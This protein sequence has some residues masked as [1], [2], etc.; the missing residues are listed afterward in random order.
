M[1]ITTHSPSLPVIENFGEI[2]ENEKGVL[3]YLIILL[4]VLCSIIS[5]LLTAAFLI[6]SLLLWGHFKPIKFFWFLTQ[7]TLSVFLISALNLLVNVPATLLL[8]SQEAAQSVTFMLISYTI[9]FFHYT[10]LFSNL[11]ISI[12]R[13]FVFFLRY[14]TDKVFEPPITY[15][16]LLFVWL[17]PFLI[18]YS[19]LSSKCKYRYSTSEKR[20]LLNCEV[21]SILSIQMFSSPTTG[22]S[23]VMDTIIQFALP[24]LIL[25]IYIAIIIKIG[26]MKRTALNKNELGILKQ[27]IFVFLIFQVTLLPRFCSIKVSGFF[28]CLLVFSSLPNQ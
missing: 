22:I 10:I 26:S 3:Y 16:W 9:D 20:F 8:I 15:I 1:V 13:A 23:M 19:F 5:T 4:F 6:I 25:V 18:E 27:A 12:Q 28:L 21:D 11:V 14:L 7:L 17:F 2:P 24:V